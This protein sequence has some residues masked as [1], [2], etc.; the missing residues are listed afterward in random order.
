M[1][2]IQDARQGL[3]SSTARSNETGHP[4]IAMPQ[5]LD[6]TLATSAFSAPFTTVEGRRGEVTSQRLLFDLVEY[7]SPAERTPTK[8]RQTN[9]STSQCDLRPNVP[10][11]RTNHKFVTVAK[12]PDGRGEL[13]HIRTSRDK[14]LRLNHKGRNLN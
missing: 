4:P 13:A 14:V 3:V 10:Y 5:A 11:T 8:V 9:D 7:K 12:A 6:K 1:W 2:G